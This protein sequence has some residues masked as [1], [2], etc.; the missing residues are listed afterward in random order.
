MHI[1]WTLLL[2]VVA[3]AWIIQAADIVRGVPT[4]PALKESAAAADSDCPSV[5]ILFAAR[6]EAEKLPG[7][8][9][10]ATNFGGSGTGTGS[11]TVSVLDRS[12]G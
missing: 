3:L 7:E 4:I 2:G 8:T 10:T 1:L 6:D 5:S 9:V 12:V 11:V